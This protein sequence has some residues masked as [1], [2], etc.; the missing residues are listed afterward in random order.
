[1]T[2]ENENNLQ[3]LIDWFNAQLLQTQKNYNNVVNNLIKQGFVL[4][5]IEYFAGSATK[6]FL[7]NE[8]EALP[9]NVTEDLLKPKKHT[10][11]KQKIVTI[12]DEVMDRMESIFDGNASPKEI[13]ELLKQPTHFSLE[14][15]YFIHNTIT[16]IADNLAQDPSML[17][18]FA[19]HVISSRDAKSR[20]EIYMAFKPEVRQKIRDEVA[21][22]DKRAASVAVDDLA[23]PVKASVALDDMAQRMKGFFSKSDEQLNQFSLFSRAV[24]TVIKQIQNINKTNSELTSASYLNSVRIYLELEVK[25]ALIKNSTYLKM[26]ADIDK[27]LPREDNVKQP[28][29]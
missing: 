27:V 17:P 28:K 26:I 19:E 25:N 1:M 9:K 16:Q 21:L 6:P 7:K 3:E 5:A 20:H 8:P 18:A 11:K 22:A 23:K 4:K 2:I 29:I 15:S 14:N 12:R 13:V 24:P 10:A